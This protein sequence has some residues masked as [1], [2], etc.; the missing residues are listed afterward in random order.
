MVPIAWKSQQ[1]FFSIL[2]I[3]LTQLSAQNSSFLLLKRCLVL[4]KTKKS[5]WRYSANAIAEWVLGSC[6]MVPCSH[7]L[8]LPALATLMHQDLGTVVINQ[9]SVPIFTFQKSVEWPGA[10]HV[11]LVCLRQQS[12]SY[13]WP[14]QSRLGWNWSRGSERDMG[15]KVKIASAWRRWR[16]ANKG[17]EGGRREQ[18][19]RLVRLKVWF[20]SG[21]KSTEWTE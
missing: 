15:E 10:I 9:R 21:E 11:L 6:W 14:M 12:I 2:F 3:K 8:P 19:W 4:E 16:R 1:D 5:S 13:L 18:S 17:G 7:K 20:A